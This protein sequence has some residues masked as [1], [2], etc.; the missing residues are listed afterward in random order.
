MHKRKSL[1]EMEHPYLDFPYQMGGSARPS[2]SDIWETLSGGLPRENYVVGPPGSSP[3]PFEGELSGHRLRFGDLGA[4]GKVMPTSNESVD[5]WN[6]PVRWQDPAEAS[7][8]WL[9]NPERNEL[10][11]GVYGDEREDNVPALPR[12]PQMY[13]EHPGRGPAIPAIPQEP[14]VLEGLKSWEEYF[15]GQPP[16]LQRVNPRIRRLQDIMLGLR[17]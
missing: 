2:P 13:D 5:I 10:H 12:L 8:F 16:D 17:P 7:T 4:P 9:F 3:S 11:G 6:A 15:E 14:S 1:F